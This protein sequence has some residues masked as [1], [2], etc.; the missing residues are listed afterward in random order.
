MVDRDDDE[1]DLSQNDVSTTSDNGFTD[2]SNESFFSQE[3]S[4]RNDLLASDS[5]DSPKFDSDF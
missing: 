2:E 5:V 1:P 4:V 3:V